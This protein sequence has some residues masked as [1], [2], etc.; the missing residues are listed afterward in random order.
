MTERNEPARYG[1][2]A[3]ALHWTLF[4]LVVVVGILGLL[5]DTW[6]RD[7]QRW[8]INLHALVGILLWLVLLVRFGWRIGNPPPP[9]PTSIGRGARSLAHGVHRLLY[10]LLFVT[11][12]V[13]AITFIWHGRALDFGLFQI[14]LPIARDPKVF[15]P[16]EDLHAYLAYALFALIAAHSAAALWHFLVGRD[17]VL[18]RMWPTR[19]R[20]AATSRRPAPGRPDPAAGE[21]TAA[22]DPFID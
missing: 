6:P 19:G 9:L 1:T 17:G 7:V 14:R 18:Q 16:T 13:G 2:A 22:N 4:A 10:L 11:P 12:I 5:H 3:I 20:P 8:W 15:E 21:D